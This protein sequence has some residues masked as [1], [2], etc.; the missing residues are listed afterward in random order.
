MSIC[1]LDRLNPE[2][3]I[4]LVCCKCKGDCTK[5]WCVCNK[6]NTNCTVLCGFG[7]ICMNT[8]SHLPPDTNFDEDNDE[9]EDDLDQCFQEMDNS[10]SE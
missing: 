5:G 9:T 1:T 8:D 10:E 4:K 2:G 7:H 3:L 6:G